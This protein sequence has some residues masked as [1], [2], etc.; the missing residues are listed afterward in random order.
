MSTRNGQI[1]MKDIAII[2]AFPVYDY[3]KVVLEVGCGN[4]CIDF[5]LASMGF[6]VY[7]TDIKKHDTWEGRKNLVFYRSDIFNLA[8]FPVKEASV[9]ICSQVLEHLKNYKHAL[10]NLLHL[11]TIRLII[12]VP[13]RRSFYDPS[14]CNF[15]SDEATVEFRD[16]KE[17]AEPCKPYRTTISKIITKP[18]DRGKQYA[19]LI[20]VDKRQ[21]LR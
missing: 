20:V 8:S 9:V 21:K 19:Y 2:D 1:D 15:W 3:E 11:T 17:L 14:H 5:K 7:A 13:Y 4:G 6:L 12:T 18:Q 10:S 16:I